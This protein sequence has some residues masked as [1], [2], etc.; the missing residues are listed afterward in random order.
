MRNLSKYIFPLLAAALVLVQL[1]FFLGRRSVEGLVLSTERAPVSPETAGG[2]QKSHFSYGETAE[3]QEKALPTAGETAGGAE[4]PLLPPGEANESPSAPDPSPAGT[5]ENPGPAEKL[6]LNTA[7]LEQLMELPGIGEARARR[8]LDCR[9]ARGGFGAVSE[10]L[11]V[12]GIGAG[13]FSR[14]ME[15]VC[16]EEM[17]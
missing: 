4:R 5:Q 8:I 16:V 14:I 1:G 6:N 12:D 10:L 13:I 3:G 17:P 9:E 15:L 2:P 11:E 7:T